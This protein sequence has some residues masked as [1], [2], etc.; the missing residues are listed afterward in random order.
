MNRPFRYAMFAALYFV[1]GVGLAYF[2]TFQKPYLARFGIDA[3]EIGLLTALLLLPFILKIFIG[4]LSDRVN[5]FGMGHRKPYM[6]GGLLLAALGFGAGALVQPDTALTLYVIAMFCGSF[7][8]TLFDSTTDGYAVD[9]TP[10]AE[11][12]RVQGIMVGG[13]AVGFVLLS[14][15]F[16]QLIGA[17]GSYRVVFIVMALVMLLPLVWVLRVEE[18]AARDESQQFDWAAFRELGRP[19]FMVF[20]VY[21]VIYSAVSFGIDGLPALFMDQVFGA[22]PQMLGSF[23]V[24]RGLGAI[25]GALAGG[26]L[27][28]RGGRRL[29]TF[30][31]I[32]LIGI[33]GALFAAAPGAGAVV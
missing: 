27:L 24:M 13:R 11:Q 17:F 6:V 28:D 19:R 22:S 26:L 14:F 23:G 1:Q 20:A 30:A 12:G 18:P 8:V 25:A 10:R 32:G 2:R 15:G 3:D 5:L 29:S 21:A 31:A 33:V 7:A 4:M 9:T 16:G